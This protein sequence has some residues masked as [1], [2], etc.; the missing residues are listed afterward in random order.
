M[1]VETLNVNLS[2]NEIYALLKGIDVDQGLW[3]TMIARRIAQMGG[4]VGYRKLRFRYGA[5][6]H[7][8]LNEV[9]DIYVTV[10]K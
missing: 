1:S 6:D 8:P 5:L 3:E 7:L 4:A 9:W 2:R 10:R